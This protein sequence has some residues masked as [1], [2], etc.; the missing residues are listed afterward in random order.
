MR[1]KCSLSPC[2]TVTAIVLRVH[3]KI[4]DVTVARQI[5]LS[6]NKLLEYLQHRQPVVLTIEQFE[7]IRLLLRNLASQGAR[8]I[9]ARI[10][11]SFGLYFVCCT[12]T[13]LDNLSSM[14]SDGRLATVLRR[15]FGL[16][17]L[18]N[19]EQPSKDDVQRVMKAVEIERFEYDPKSYQ[20]CQERAS[21]MKGKIVED[22]K[23][24][25][26]HE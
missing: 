21:C 23:V 14:I 1:T 15:L 16:L 8:L 7:C 19:V 24:Y 13:G 12:S 3:A 4:R 18:Q 2:T 11:Q 22:F 6:T 20:L 17:Q 9:C 10:E 25:N 26:M 5:E